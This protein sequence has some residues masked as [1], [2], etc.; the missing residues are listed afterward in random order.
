MGLRC[1]WRGRGL[2]ESL[3]ENYRAT[4]WSTAHLLHSRSVWDTYRQQKHNANLQLFQT[5]T[6]TDRCKEHIPSAW[7]WQISLLLLTVCCGYWIGQRAVNQ[8]VHAP[9]Q[10]V[11]PS[12]CLYRGGART[13]DPHTDSDPYCSRWVTRSV[14]T[15]H[16]NMRNNIL[17]LLWHMNDRWNKI[18]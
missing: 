10:C 9:V 16:E 3:M 12:L 1:W 6:D 13:L 18:I 15:T 17:H 2:Q 7:Y 4:W 14:K 5:L 11:F 8:S